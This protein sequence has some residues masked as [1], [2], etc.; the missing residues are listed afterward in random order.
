[1]KTDSFANKE[2][3]KICKSTAGTLDCNP[4]HMWFH[5]LIVRHVMSRIYSEFYS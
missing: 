4:D 1:M 2:G 3:D 5:Y